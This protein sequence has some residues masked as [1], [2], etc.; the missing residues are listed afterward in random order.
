MTDDRENGSTGDPLKGLQAFVAR[1]SRELAKLSPVVDEWTVRMRDAMTSSRKW[2]SVNGPKV[3]AAGLTLKKLS[4]DS[5]VENWSALTQ[6]EWI[7]ALQLMCADDGVPLAWTP[8]A[9]IV[10]ALV[11]AED[12]NERNAVLL[13]HEVEIEAHARGL[14]A[15]ASR[16]EL[17]ILK[18]AIG[19]AWNAWD[20]GLIV[21]AQAAAAV[22]LGDILLQHGYREFGP[23]RIA[24]EPFRD[25]PPEDWKLTEIRTTALMCALSTAVQREDQV[26][27]QG[28]NRHV[29]L[30]RVDP[31]QY[32]RVNALRGLMLVTAAVRE[33]QFGLSNEWVNSPGFE[34]PP[35][36]A[37]AIQ[38]DPT[39]GGRLSPPATPE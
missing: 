35:L 33:L 34:L 17:D 5:R 30:H 28:F 4:A 16:P 32:S 27:L 24:W 21:P 20:A 15:A 22:A 26:D 37:K 14:L 25:T 1:G 38:D 2:L 31:A 29:S 10:K 6:D 7:L 36:G 9:D 3:V 18:A 12:H 23:F 13:A 39:L 8:P 11:A 19:E